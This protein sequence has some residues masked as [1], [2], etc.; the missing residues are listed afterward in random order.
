VNIVLATGNPGKAAEFEALWS[1]AAVD[2]APEGFA[3]EETGTTLFQ[4]AWI[5]A[6]ALR[7][8]A[9]AEAGS[10]VLADDSGLVVHAL[11]GRPGVFSSRY[12]GEDATDEDN[13]R[14]L[15]QELEGEDDRRAAFVCVLVALAPADRMLVASGCCPGVIA[16][17]MRGGKG[18]GYDPVF[19]PEGEERS[20]AEM[21]REEKAAI[22]HRGRAARRMSSLLGLVAA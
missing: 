15:L 1:G 17:A 11:G 19:I 8:D 4:N 18:F 10:V 6:A 3:P 14:R 2:R 21:T 20:M 13:C 16:T 9:A 7:R 5:K 22:S 12:A